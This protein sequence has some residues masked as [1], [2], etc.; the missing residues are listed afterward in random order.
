MTLEISLFWLRLFLSVYAGVCAC[1]VEPCCLLSHLLTS[2][3]QLNYETLQPSLAYDSTYPH[4]PMVA[5]QDRH[6][7]HQYTPHQ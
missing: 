3:N 2:L 4:E 1:T 6:Y 7:I 5:D